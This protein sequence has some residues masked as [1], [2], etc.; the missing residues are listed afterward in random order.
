MLNLSRDKEYHVVAKPTSIMS[1]TTPI[2]AVA[3]FY[4]K[5]YHALPEIN[6]PFTKF[7]ISF[8]L[9]G[10]AFLSCVRFSSESVLVNT[11][12]WPENATPTKEASASLAAMCHSTILCAGLI[13][14]FMTQKYDVSAKIKDQGA[15]KKWWPD[16]A[17]ALLQF[18]TGYM[19]YDTCVNILWLRWN[20]ELQTFDFETDDYLFLGHHMATT[21]YMS[22]CRIIGAGYMSAMICMLLG[23]L[24][25]PLQNSYMVAEVAMT[26]DCCNG[27]KMQQF[28]SFIK[29]A[30]AAAYF[31]V[32]VLIGPPTFILVTY[33][34]LLTKRGRANIPIGLNIFWNMLIWGVIFGSSSWIVKCYNILADFVNGVEQEL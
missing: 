16:F 11:F 22:S 3:N 13:V 30:F 10:A 1:K 7:N 6:V 27:S 20:S 4:L 28:Y 12:G 23:E 33:E 8:S 9:L 18:C 2:P 29:V 15:D 19:V 25:N 21:I 34:L 5:L 14:A 17:D 26:L 32:R 31:T 24:T